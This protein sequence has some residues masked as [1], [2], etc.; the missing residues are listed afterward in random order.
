MNHIS[1]EKTYFTNHMEWTQHKIMDIKPANKYRI[2]RVPDTFRKIMQHML[3]KFQ[4][5]MGVWSILFCFKSNW[6]GLKLRILNLDCLQETLIAIWKHHF[7][8]HNQNIIWEILNY[9]ELIFF[10]SLVK[11]MFSFYLKLFQFSFL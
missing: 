3:R 4:Y 1:T 2:I 5:S 7:T 9:H 8:W 6:F 10:C 11:C